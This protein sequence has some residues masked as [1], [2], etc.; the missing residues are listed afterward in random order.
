M[1][2]AAAR[3]PK[4]KEALIEASTPLESNFLFY[5]YIA[6]VALE[7]L[8]LSS[9]VPVIGAL[10]PTIIM[11][12]VMVVGLLM[13]KDRLRGRL[14]SDTAKWL[15]YFAIYV[16]LTLPFVRWPGSVLQVTFEAWIRAAV[17][18]F[19]TA[20]VV[21]SIP[22]LRVFVTTVFLCQVIRVLEPLYLHVTDG[23][24]GSKA[25]VGDGE[26]MQR[27]GGGPYDVVNPNGL[28]FVILTAFTF[29][30]LMWFKSPRAGFL[31]KA[32]CLSIIG[33][34]MYALILTA[35]RSSFLA[36][37]IIWFFLILKSQKKAVLIAVSIGCIVVAAGS[38]DDLQRDRY[39]SIFSSD[40][41]S[42]AT[43]EGR[44]KGLESGLQLGL[45]KPI[46]G[47]GLGTSGEAHYHRYGKYKV[48]HN[49]Y[50]EAL[51]DV[52]IIGTIIF[53]LFLRSLFV[54]ARNLRS[55]IAALGQQSSRDGAY[56]V[57]LGDAIQVWMA[58][59]LF[60]SFAYFGLMEW[61]WYLV[62]GLCAS[63]Q[64]LLTHV[65]AA[66][67]AAPSSDVRARSS[68]RVGYAN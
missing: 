21:D 29:L 35:S 9:R 38:L 37:V 5:T 63:A 20:L 43:A 22:R 36:L 58:M 42:G 28:G 40:T 64:R 62:A 26:F 39:M 18:F 4:G 7:F 32:V 10:R 23:S 6:F 11:V 65:P 25:Y 60:I 68:Q 27:L 31:G 13:N 48:A 19:F 30:Y 57:S 53:V 47:H 1:T 16:V 2:Y 59:S 66:L 24:W 8:R 52:G 44:L 49:L 33:A 34:M 17:F 41:R 55:G 3:Q 56:L 12:A 67:V 54:A 15:R 45:E 51:S 14:T 46:F 50:L 61:H